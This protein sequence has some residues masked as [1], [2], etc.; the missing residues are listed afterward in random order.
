MILRA[1]D[2]AKVEPD[3]D[4]LAHPGRTIALIVRYPE[5]MQRPIVQLGDQA[6]IGRPLNQCSNYLRV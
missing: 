1:E 2:A 4:L 3:V 5:L 6:K